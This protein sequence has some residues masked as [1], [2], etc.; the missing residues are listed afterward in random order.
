MK[1]ITLFIAASVFAITQTVNAQPSHSAIVSNNYEAYFAEAYQQYPA[2]PVGILESVAYNH[3]R[4]NH[5]THTAGEP[6]SCTGIPLVYGVMGLTLDGKNYFHNNLVTV[7]QLS[8]ISTDD[9]MNSPEKCILA[10]AAAYA[11]EKQKLNISSNNIEDQLPVLKALSELPSET[12][13]QEYALNSDMYVILAFL[14]NTNYQ[15]FYKLP[16]YNINIEK[17]FGTDTYRMLTAPS[18]YIEDIN[19]S[20]K[21]SGSVNHNAQAT[22]DYAGAIWNPAA[23]C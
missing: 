9:I 11:A 16:A 14:N 10:Y 6:Q 19:K 3:T 4:F 7:S 20:D 15:K 22:G 8:G 18:N 17:V 21:R 1:K 2:V 13:G 12:T 23:S 5:M